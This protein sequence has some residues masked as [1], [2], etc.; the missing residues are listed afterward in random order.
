LVSIS[1]GFVSNA[2]APRL[3]D[4]NARAADKVEKKLKQHFPDKDALQSAVQHSTELLA[5]AP[6]LRNAAIHDYS[7]DGAIHQAKLLL[8]AW[9]AADAFESQHLS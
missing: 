7:V 8:E 5:L 3:R 1:Q 6:I 2:F 4:L 9:T